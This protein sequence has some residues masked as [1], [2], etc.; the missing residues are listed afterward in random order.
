MLFVYLILFLQGG[1]IILGAV[2]EVVVSEAAVLDTAGVIA[3][4]VLMLLTGAILILLGFQVFRGSAAARTPAM[5]LELMIVILSAS[6][7]VGGGLNAGF[8]ALGL[9]PAAAA[10]ILL[11]IRPTQQWLDETPEPDPKDA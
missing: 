9:L 5:V 8:A 10:L 11:F 6:L 2:A 3:L 1:F 7:L 4:L